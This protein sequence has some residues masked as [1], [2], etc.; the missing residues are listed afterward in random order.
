M[1]SVFPACYSRHWQTALCRRRGKVFEAMNTALKQRAD[2]P[3]RASPNL[4][5]AA[6]GEHAMRSDVMLAFWGSV[7]RNDPEDPMIQWP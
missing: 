7:H 3:D 2:F 4:L 6:G 1:P 5:K